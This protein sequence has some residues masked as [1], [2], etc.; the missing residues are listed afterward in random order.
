MSQI[1]S[2]ITMNKTKPGL[3]SPE[4]LKIFDKEEC[5]IINRFSQRDWYVTRAEEVPIASSTY[6]IVLLKPTDKISQCFN[7]YRELV[8][9]FSP[10]E[11]FEPRSI[12]AIEYLNIQELR[13][14]EICSIVISK[15]ESVEVKINRILK[16]NQ[17]SRII[18]PFSYKELLDNT[19][20]EYVVNKFR[21]HFYCRDL[22]GIQ[23]P[24]KKDLYFFGRKELIH[25]IVNKHLNGENAGVFGL[26]KTGKTSIIYGVQRALD[27]KNS[28]SVFIDCQTL[29]LK[30]WNV[31]L[32]GI[33]DLLRATSNVKKSETTNTSLYE[34]EMYVSDYFYNDIKTIYNKNGKRSIL[35]IFDEIENITF[36]TS[37][38]AGWKSGEYFLKF[39]QVIRSTYQRFS[40]DNIFTYLIAGTN[41]RC[42]ERSEII[43]SDNPIFAQFPPIFIAP[44]NY[45][46]TKEMLDKL[47]GYMGLTFEPETCTHIVE[48]FGGHPLLIRQMCSYIHSNTDSKRPAKINRHIYAKLKNS[49]F[50]E[51][52]GFMKYAQMVLGVLSNWYED[53][54][55]M[56]IWLA[57]GDVETFKGLAQVSPDYV[58]HL[59]KYGIIEQT[60]S[61]YNFKIE[62]I[63]TYLL[64]KNKYQKLNLTDSEKQEEISMRRNAIE[65]QLR[66]I[67]RRQL[68][69]E[70]GEPEAKKV[71]IG[72][73]YGKK[74]ISMYE[75]LP[76]KDF[77]DPN[78]HTLLLSTL[79]EV[80]RKH[81]NLFENLFE[82]NV[83]IF[84][85]K[86]KLINYYRKPDAH[87]AKIK[88]SDF[89]S[90]RGAMQWLEEI[91][92]DYE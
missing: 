22:F 46:Q 66:Q 61:D 71:M 52:S 85:A 10:Y 47:G 6:K 55:Q 70:F 2:Q 50:Q 15:D 65:P 86:A 43:D 62:A 39:W 72:E 41:P 51:E 18:I 40:D 59:V 17:E 3:I 88:D 29:H 74:N 23:D 49:F 1:M 57:L 53:E 82:V 37:V 30:S 14:E 80:I 44:F 16:S 75:S 90:F 54:Y 31:A 73:L 91:L 56:L 64:T 33:V 8:V 11:T 26:R 9:V 84:S 38:S 36:D 7:I 42:I 5:E 77:F 20:N 34:Q 4:I 81:Y 58:T 48:D 89:T 19:D 83:E 67:V 60:G 25:D 35:L 92:S 79:F 76:Y 32:G 68:K 21:T 78:K 24:L 13:L 45:E 63:K 69:S 28:T 27:R 87:A 12:D